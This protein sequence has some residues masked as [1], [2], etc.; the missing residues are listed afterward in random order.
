LYKKIFI[1][2]DNSKYSNYCSELGIS[3]AKEF[4]SELI[5]GH[6]YAAN[7]HHERFR[8]MESGLPEKYRDGK[9]LK[10]Q[11]KLHNTLIG[12]GLRMI[13]NSYLDSLDKR[14]RAEGVRFTR[15]IQEGKN[16]LE[17]VKDINNKDYDLVIIGIRGL[18]ETNGNLIGSVCER[19]V[20]RINTDVLVVKN[21]KLLNG[22][23]R[24]IVAVDGSEQ[25]FA[26][27]K[28]ASFLAKTYGMNIEAIS[29][30]DHHYH[31][32]AFAGISNVLSEEMGEVFK[33]EEQEK[34]HED[35]IDKGLE[36][37]YQDHLENAARI[38]K[39]MGI[40]IKTTILQGKPYDQILKHTERENPALL[41]IGRT[42][43]HSVNG[44]DM[45]S[46][47]ENII[48]MAKCNILITNSP[49]NAKTNFFDT[50]DDKMSENTGHAI[51]EDAKDDSYISRES[52]EQY[53]E[54]KEEL[55]WA[56][57]AKARISK[58]PLFVKKMAVKQI[59]DY[60]RAIGAKEIT[61]KIME[62]AKA[63]WEDSM[64]FSKCIEM[65]TLQK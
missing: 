44:L 42:G 17:L 2:I 9:E 40:G 28:A 36:K 59:E 22:N 58:V 10:K 15:N 30:F 1:P 4:S 38:A 62:E 48:R 45:G 51:E 26:G 53:S 6:V 23:G 49:E 29:A 46:A 65:D 3:I 27:V 8:E 11:R 18:G 33:S 21:D 39:N 57:E 16:Y 13:S 54:E 41:I 63:K 7:L 19:V 14:C 61:S 24:I 55:I 50:I 32:V 35:V 60:A 56:E 12:R 47:T 31:L 20:R 34:L 52:R 5:G 25:S 43:I 64:S 37:I